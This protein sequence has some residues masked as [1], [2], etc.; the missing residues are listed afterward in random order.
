MQENPG[1]LPLSGLTVLD[2]TT[3]LPGPL[4]TL[5]MAEAGAQVIKVESLDGDPMRKMPP[6]WG[7]ESA[8]FAMLNRGKKSIRLDLKDARQ[9]EHLLPLIRRADILV[10]QFRPGVME[11]LGLGYEALR[12][13]NPGLIYCSITGFGQS[14]PRASQPGH[15]LTFQALSGLLSLSCGSASQPVLPNFFAADLAGGTWPAF[16]NVLLAL[17][18]RQKTGEGLHLDISMS[19]ALFMFLNWA[20]AQGLV[21][22]DWPKSGQAA[23]TG[24]DPR[25]NLYATKDG[26]LVAVAAME[27]KFWNILCEAIGLARDERDSRADP[28]KTKRKLAEIFAA[29]DAAHWRKV[30]AENPCCCAVVETLEDAMRDLHFHETGVFDH[31]L[32]NEDG[33]TLPANPLALDPALRIHPAK[34]ATSA[35]ALGAHNDMLLK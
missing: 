21:E 25:Y 2:F 32:E 24:A 7:R 1:F 26:R 28:L 18:Q 3:L 14:G 9:L 11:R 33:D 13:L 10:E 30:F 16:S 8:F 27:D 31:T 6:L 4:A 34:A 17:L 12:I 15:D 22:D 19:G 5:M 23:Y 20:M 29:E 35:P